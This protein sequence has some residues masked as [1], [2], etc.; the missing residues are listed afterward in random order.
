[1]KNVAAPLFGP[2]SDWHFN[3]CL[4]YSHDEWD[5]YASGF[6]EAAEVLARQILAER[7]NIDVLAIP[8]VYLC[9][10]AIELRL[11]RLSQRAVSL[12]L[13][14]AGPN[15]GSHELRPLWREVRLAVKRLGWRDF[16]FRVLDQVISSFDRID[17]RG[18]AFRYP[19]TLDGQRAI[20]G[21]RH[22][23]VL[24]FYEQVAEA[25]DLLSSVDSAFSAAEDC[26]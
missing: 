14:S 2:R 21:L 4:N 10:H 26:I 20:P 5:F 11:K 18:M 1:M 22:I 9:R 19:T 23:N 13:I 7:R 25:V 6:Q 12:Q 15:R 3:A 8:L 24:Q 16:P 17:A